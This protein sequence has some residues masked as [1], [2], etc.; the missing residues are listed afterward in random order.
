MGTPLLQ[1][2]LACCILRHSLC[3]NHC[4]YP[5]PL[6]PPTTCHQSPGSVPGSVLRIP[7][8]Q[9]VP[10]MLFVEM[11]D[12]GTEVAGKAKMGLT[13]TDIMATIQE[14]QAANRDHQTRLF[15][16]I[17]NSREEV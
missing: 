4:P 9:C 2:S 17:A 1:L 7:V 14:S 8:A 15:Q 11:S 13:L 5:Y 10:E 16:C 6:T 12:M 3:P